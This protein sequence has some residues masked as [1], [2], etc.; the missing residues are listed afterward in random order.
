MLFTRVKALSWL[1]Q[2][3]VY[4]GQQQRSSY[5]YQT[6]NPIYLKKN[7][8]TIN[9]Q[10]NNVL[11]YKKKMTEV[12]VSYANTILK[13]ENIYLRNSSQVFLTKCTAAVIRVQILHLSQL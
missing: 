10:G 6:N 12:K 9:Y 13:V 1:H 8:I 3:H 4:V 2:I 5:F 11:N 7:S